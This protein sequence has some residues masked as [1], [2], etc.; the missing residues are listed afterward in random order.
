MGTNPTKAAGNIYCRCRKEAA[1]YNDRLHS[2]EGAAESLGISVSTLADYELGITKVVPVDKVLLMADLYNAPQLKNYYCTEICP[3][4]MGE[5]KIEMATLDRIAVRAVATLRKASI[6]E[7]KLL[8]IVE[9]GV[10]SEDD[11]STFEEII[12]HLDELSEVALTLKL[13]AEKNLK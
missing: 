7:G 9:D 12:K 4:G 5:P 11:K 3:L 2:R 13:W 1:N 6:T 8:E 10:I